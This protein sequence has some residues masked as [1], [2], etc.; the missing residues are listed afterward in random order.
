MLITIDTSAVLAVLVNESHKQVI[1]EH[2]E[3]SELQSPESIDAEIGNALSAMLKRKRISLTKTKQ[4]INQFD[5]VPIR[6]TPI[7]LNEAL[8]LSKE[9]NIYAYDGYVLDCAKQYRTPL[10]SLDRRMVDVAKELNITVLEV[11]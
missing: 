4:I 11:S 1:I 2:T 10:L 6:R 5:L 3:N 7:R 8:K 9:F